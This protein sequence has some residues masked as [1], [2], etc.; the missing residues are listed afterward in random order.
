M[1]CQQLDAGQRA[2]NDG[3]FTSK[4]QVMALWG[5]SKAVSL[6]GCGYLMLPSILYPP[7]VMPKSWMLGYASG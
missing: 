7:T 5:S 6:V 4:L 1:L 3:E 2:T